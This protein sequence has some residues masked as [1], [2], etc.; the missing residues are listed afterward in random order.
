[1][2]YVFIDES[3]DL[4]FTR[5][6]TKYYVIASV[7]TNDLLQI[8]RVPKKVRKTLKKGKKNI[9]EFKFTRSSDL[10]RRRFLERL[11]KADVT[12]SA[13]VL[14]KRTVYDY[15][16]DKKEKIHN[17]LAGFIAE[18]L[19]YEYGYE[20]EFEIVV[21]KFIMSREKRSEFDWYLTHRFLN[22]YQSKGLPKINIIHA[23]SQE[24]PGLQAADFIAGSIFQYYEKGNPKYYEIIKPKLRVEL[25]KWF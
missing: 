11:V 18:S 9:P 23:D 2:L 19:S 3:G 4:G 16:R 5:K 20:T 17:Y 6:S 8:N 14:Q 7:E 12:F 15:L 21:D 25:K 13:I 1:M 10:I 22:S 24:H